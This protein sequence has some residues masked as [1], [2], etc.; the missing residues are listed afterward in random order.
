MSL[1]TWF[2]LAVSL[3]LVLVSQPKP[4][5]RGGSKARSSTGALRCAADLPGGIELRDAVA[6]YPLCA[7]C[8][9]TSVPASGRSRKRWKRRR[10]TA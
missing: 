3:V 5:R 1:L 2:A 8:G 7:R 6:A 10:R 4:S 9:D